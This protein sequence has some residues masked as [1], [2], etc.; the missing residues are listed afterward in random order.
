MASPPPPPTRQTRFAGLGLRATV[1]LIAAVPALAAYGAFVAIQSAARP[2]DPWTDLED[3]AR[4]A[5]SALDALAKLESER[6]ALHR[7]LI[8][9]RHAAFRSR[10]D[11]AAL[12]KGTRAGGEIDL[13]AWIDLSSNRV[14]EASGGGLTSGATL[15]AALPE[16]SAALAKK[17]AEIDRG[18]AVTIELGGR[19][20]ALG[21]PTDRGRRLVRAVPPPDPVL[22]PFKAADSALV[23]AAAPIVRAPAIGF[24]KGRISR[25]SLAVFLLLA[26]LASGILGF[27]WL[28]VRV[29]NPLSTSLDATNRWLH[30]DVSARPSTDR[31]ALP[32]REIART[33]CALMDAGDRKE[34]QAS[35][36]TE[37]SIRVLSA[38]LAAI[39]QGDLG[40]PPPP[41]APAFEPLR[42][43]VD[44]ARKRVASRISELYRSGV[45]VAASGSAIVQGAR[46][47]ARAGSECLDAIS[48]ATKEA[49]A[50]DE[51]IRQRSTALGRA[52]DDLAILIAFHRRV[53]VQLRTELGVASKRAEELR[54][55][56]EQL[57]ER[58][59]DAGALDRALDLLAGVAAASET[60][61]VRGL[62][63]AGLP[64]AQVLMQ[65]RR[66]RNALEALRR[67]LGNHTNG[68]QEIA[69]SHASTAAAQAPFAPELEPSVSGSLRGGAMAFVRG[70]E[71]MVEGLRALERASK[72]VQSRT[73]QIASG[74]ETVA[75][76]GPKLSSAIAPF[77][78]GPAVDRELVE[79]LAKAR[80]AYEEAGREG[81][82]ESGRA[83]MDDVLHAAEESRARV[84]RLIAVTEAAADVLREPRHI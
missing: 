57:T 20:Y 2:E 13:S 62:E 15:S 44:V 60:V 7:T 65:V 81:L 51:E 66:S 52:L 79:R 31:G 83:M 61:V 19:V 3:R 73:Q 8:E 29:T 14:I 23:A 78:L 55:L 80:A 71:R 42:T 72:V 4:A 18:S 25:L 76:H 9:E 28:G 49:A 16:L 38:H 6:E 34:T 24:A 43:A 67:E 54:E 10:T 58:S 27:F 50:A 69:H 47:L 77:D 12:V 84:S 5:R 37:E 40:S 53:S 70:G 1:A 33:L 35:L 41:V 26:S 48:R 21:P 75:E 68:L 46:R 64:S 30:G 74:A 63:G 36:Q 39:G 59:D 17:K 11:A 32:A 22:A 82:T 45:E 56:S